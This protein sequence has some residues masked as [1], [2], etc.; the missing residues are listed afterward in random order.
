[1]TMLYLDRPGT[2]PSKAHLMT[3]IPCEENSILPPLPCPAGSK[4]IQGDAFHVDIVMAEAPW[5][6][7][8]PGSGLCKEFFPGLG[9]E[10]HEFDAAAAVAPHGKGGR[11]VRV[12]DLRAVLVRQHLGR[13][14][15]ALGQH[16]AHQPVV[17]EAEVVE[18]DAA[19]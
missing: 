5:P 8:L 9:G 3:S 13:Q 17:L 11:P 7:Q 18:V 15:V 14:A 2:A 16:V 4:R 10:A 19:Q 1:M 6:K 12:A